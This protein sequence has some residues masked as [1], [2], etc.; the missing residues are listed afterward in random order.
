[1]LSDNSMTH[2]S[3]PSKYSPPAKGPENPPLSQTLNYSVLIMTLLSKKELRKDRY[4]HSI[5]YNFY[6]VWKDR[7]P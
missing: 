1:M 6:R 2:H 3:R 7:V 4:P 5:F